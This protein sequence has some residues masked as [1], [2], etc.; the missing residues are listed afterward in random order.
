M[1]P[2]LPDRLL[3]AGFH[4]LAEPLRLQIL[5]LLRDREVCVCDLCDCLNV[6]QSKL[7]FHLKVLKEAGLV[8]VRQEGR[9]SYY[10]LN[11]P[12]LQAL[13]QYLASFQQSTIAAT[14]AC[15]E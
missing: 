8:A 4:A 15:C 10:R 2:T 1:L 6:P 9:W 14:R 5:D 11:L 7:S 13:E 12:Q 3:T